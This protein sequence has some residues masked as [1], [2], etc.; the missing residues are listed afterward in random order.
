MT[1]EIQ[2]KFG[3]NISAHLKDLTLLFSKI[4]LLMDIGPPLAGC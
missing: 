2:L 4:L 1:A 3:E